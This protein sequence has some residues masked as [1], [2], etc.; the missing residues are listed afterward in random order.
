MSGLSTTVF[1]VISRSKRQLL[2]NLVY[3]GKT[4]PVTQCPKFKAKVPIYSVVINPVCDRDRNNYKSTVAN[5]SKSLYQCLS[6]F[7][8]FTRLVAFYTYYS[9]FATCAKDS[10]D[11]KENNEERRSRHKGCFAAKR[12][13]SKLENLAKARQVRTVTKDQP[14]ENDNDMGPARKIATR[15]KQ[16]CS[17]MA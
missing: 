4:L 14:D 7:V 9:S 16:V 10:N 6:R 1:S 2:R 17:R 15:S 12:R 5:S 8:C 11:E 13:V 3:A